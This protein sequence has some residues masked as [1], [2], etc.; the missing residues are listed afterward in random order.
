MGGHS[1]L[2][3]EELGFSREGVQAARAGKYMPGLPEQ[4][5]TLV[6]FARRVAES[7]RQVD[8][9]DIERLRAVGLDDATIVEV[10]SVCM[11]SAFTNTLT[12]ALKLDTD[13]DALGLE[14]YF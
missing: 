4:Q 10:L 8:E 14:G 2:L 1:R 7:P 6:R 13:L 11:V 3:V 12:D 5:R 9:S